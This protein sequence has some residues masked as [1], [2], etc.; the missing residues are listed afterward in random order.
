ML[1]GLVVVY[2]RNEHYRQAAEMKPV[3]EGDTKLLKFWLKYSYLQLSR[4]N[5]LVLAGEI[6]GSDST[7]A[8]ILHVFQLFILCFSLFQSESERKTCGIGALLSIF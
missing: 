5:R 4:E 7:D 2:S 3:Q 8:F 1:V 6:F